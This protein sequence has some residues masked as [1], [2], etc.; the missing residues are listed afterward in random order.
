L[1]AL[2]ESGLTPEAA[3]AEYTSLH[4]LE[5]AVSPAEVA[6]ALA[7]AAAPRNPRP[8]VEG[9]GATARSGRGRPD[10]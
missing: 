6:A 7:S 1:L 5:H 9:H 10:T 3:A 4:P 8:A 2:A